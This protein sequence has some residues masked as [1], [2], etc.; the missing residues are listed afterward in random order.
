MMN[1]KLR[2][3]LQQHR[4]IL[5]KLLGIAICA[6]AATGAAAQGNSI[7][8]ADLFK[9]QWHAGAENCEQDS[10][11][12]IQVVLANKSSYVLRQ[13]KCTTFEAPFLFLLVGQSASLL[14]DTGALEFADESPV[15][16]TIKQILTDEGVAHN[17]L[18]IAHSHSHSDH[19]NGDAQFH[20]KPNVSVIGTSQQEIVEHFGFDE[21]PLGKAT[22]ELGDRAIDVISIPGHQDQ[23]IALY[24]SQTG[25]LLTGD[26]LYPGSIRVQHWDEF[27]NSI[28]RL[29]HFANENDVSMVLGAHIEMN[30]ETGKLYKIGSTYQP[31]EMPLAL[32]V[33]SLLALNSKLQSTNKAKELK[34]SRFVISPLNFFE[35]L[36]IKA[37][38]PKPKKQN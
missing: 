30:A 21:W 3:T 10:A 1:L 23:S 18:I 15:Y 28:Q 29:S 19:T 35:K 9:F 11:S 34:F 8:Y 13:N 25:W 31:R 32:E 4:R 36:L 5:L 12:K 38:S 14:V 20:G 17:P 7:G 27:A 37:L 33:Q 22:L 26:T 16:E 2:F 6:Y 24:D